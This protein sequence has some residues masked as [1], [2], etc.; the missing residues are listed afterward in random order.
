MSAHSIT[1]VPTPVLPLHHISQN[2]L[3][4][5]L[6]MRRQREALD[7]QIQIAESAVR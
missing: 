7:E 5:I 1:I 3:G 4:H 6:E 2:E